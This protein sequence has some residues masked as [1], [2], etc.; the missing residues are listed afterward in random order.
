MINWLYA[1]RLP[2]NYTCRFINHKIVFL[3]TLVAA[4]LTILSKFGIRLTIKTYDAWFFSMA[5]LRGELCGIL[6][7]CVM[8]LLTLIN[9]YNKHLFPLSSASSDNGGMQYIHGMLTKSF[10]STGNNRNSQGITSKYN[11][12]GEKH[13]KA[14][15][16][17]FVTLLIIVNCIV[18][19]S[20]N[21]LYV[22]I[23]LNYNKNIVTVTQICLALFKL[24]WNSYIVFDFFA[25]LKRV[26]FSHEYENSDTDFSEGMTN[27]ISIL[28]MTSNATCV[29]ENYKIVI[30]W[31]KVLLSCLI[32]LLHLVWLLQ[33]LAAIVFIMPFSYRLVLIQIIAFYFVRLFLIC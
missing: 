4:T 14:R 30:F 28:S 7:F 12:N 23:S 27:T 2:D 25:Y 3:I 26:Y 11:K 31:C 1:E 5:F 32:T 22:Y 10:K 19:I 8:F 17:T 24:F 16:F 9:L 33:P 21:L 6:C 15:Y 20:I 18:V 13:S 29:E